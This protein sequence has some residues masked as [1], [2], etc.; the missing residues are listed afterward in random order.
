LGVRHELGWIDSD[1]KKLPPWEPPPAPNP[2]AFDTYRAAAALLPV[3]GEPD[4]FY[5]WLVALAKGDTPGAA[6]LLHEV[7][8][9]LGKRAAALAKMHEAAGQEYVAP[10]EAGPPP[11]FPESASYRRLA[12]LGAIAARL[13]LESGNCRAAMSEIEDVYALGVQVSRGGELI[14]MLLGAAIVAISQGQSTEA[15]LSGRVAPDVLRAHA[16]RIRYLRSR[17]D[18]LA[19]ITHK[20]AMRTLAQLDSVLRPGASP[21]DVGPGAASEP[22]PS[23]VE[24]LRGHFVSSD[25]PKSREWIEDRYARLVEELDKPIAE[26]R[27]RE[28][29]GRTQADA[30]ARNDRVAQ[31]LVKHMVPVQIQARD[32]W[33]AMVTY[34]AADETIACLEAY[35]KERGSYPASLDQLVPD[36]LPDVPE[37]PW[38][39]S[40]LIYRLSSERYTLYATGPNCVDDGGATDGRGLMEPD[41]VIV[42]IPAPRE[43]T[44]PPADGP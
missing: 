20:G 39:G 8:Y 22:R 37:D 13:A 5:D 27:F 16:A 29:A 9:D 41:L 26:S 38:T 10:R 31:D 23:L 42:P 40:P 32:K 34:L 43:R 35:R 44:T 3:G 21:A 28:V 17:V 1:R 24:R 18:S 2:N 15:L 36:Y 25:L 6:A 7:R 19:R 33:A 12:R 14:D 30:E 11:D 4:A